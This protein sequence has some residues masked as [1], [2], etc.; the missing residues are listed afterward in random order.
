[1]NPRRVRAV[2]VRIVAQFRRDPRTLALIIVVPVAVLALL[3]WIIRDQTSPSTDVAVVNGAGPGAQTLVDAL[4]ASPVEGFRVASE[5][6]D[7]AAA[8]QELVDRTADIAI[9]IPRGF[10]SD[11]AA[12]RQPTIELITLGLN[13]GQDG[14]HIGRFQLALAGAVQATLPPSVANHVPQF[15]HATVYGSPNADLLDSFAPVFVG[16]FAY[17]FVFLITG[18]SFLRERVGGTLE[19]L[20]ATPVTRAEIVVGYSV[21][22]GIFATI[23]VAV[24]LLFTL[25]R[26]EVPTIGPIPSFVLGLGVPTAGNPL[27]AYLIALLLGLGAVSLGIF[28]STFARTEL[29]VIQFIP[30]V[31]VPQVFLGGILWPVETLPD[32]LQPVSRV[33]PVTYAVEGLREVIIAGRDLASQTVQIDLVALAIITGLF[34]LLAAGTIRREVV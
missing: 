2:V 26:L 14:T 29:Q 16:F 34:I 7:E 23:Q 1:M 13:P 5:P 3:G 20:L 27:L 33:L 31:I 28:L 25:M 12:G 19:R 17:F 4:R 15:Q 10:A 24:V 18:V 6:P 32:I 8:R 21:G 30:I 11:I 22:F 9:V